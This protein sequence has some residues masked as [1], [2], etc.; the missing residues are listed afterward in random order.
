MNYETILVEKQESVPGVTVVTLNRPS[1][2]NAMNT[3]MFDELLDC[4]RTLSHDEAVR[5][6]ILTGAGRSFCAGAKK[7]I[8]WLAYWPC[9]AGWRVLVRRACFWDHFWHRWALLC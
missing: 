2:L 8:P 6:M 4:A 1:L 9:S 7:C 3:R 5:C